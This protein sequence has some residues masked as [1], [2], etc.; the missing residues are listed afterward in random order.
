MVTVGRTT[1]NKQSIVASF[2]DSRTGKINIGKVFYG[3]PA[4]L[5]GG[6]FLLLQDRKHV[7]AW[8][9]RGDVKLGLS[10]S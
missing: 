3:P 8:S 6:N 4:M 2:N 5:G 7:S 9:I 10:L 1:Q